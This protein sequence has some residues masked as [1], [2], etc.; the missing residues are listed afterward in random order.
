MII[1]GEVGGKIDSKQQTKKQT[2][3]STSGFKKKIDNLKN[4]GGI[5]SYLNLKKKKNFFRLFDRYNNNNDDKRFR[6]IESI[7]ISIV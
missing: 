4:Y 3:Q 5:R 1:K 2:I 7:D 6:L